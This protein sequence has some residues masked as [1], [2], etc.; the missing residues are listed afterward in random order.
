M[1]SMNCADLLREPDTSLAAVARQVS[2]GSPFALSTAFKGARGQPERVPGTSRG[3]LSGCRSVRVQR[4][5][6]EPLTSPRN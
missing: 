5:L 1:L 6:P 2:Y 3:W 4:H